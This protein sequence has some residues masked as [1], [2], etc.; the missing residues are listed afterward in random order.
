MSFGPTM[1]VKDVLINFNCLDKL[2]SL[3]RINPRLIMINNFSYNASFH[4][5]IH[6]NIKGFNHSNG[7]IYVDSYIILSYIAMYGALKRKI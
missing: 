2:F 3:C 1:L 4:V 6:L 7:I 5:E